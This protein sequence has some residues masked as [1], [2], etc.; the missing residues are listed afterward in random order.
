MI[1]KILA[2]FTRD[3]KVSLKD[4]I[5]LYIII[6]P[7]LFAIV[8]NVFTPGINDST[9][10]LAMLASDDA[11][12]IAYL[13]DFAKVELFS[14]V[15]AIENRIE[16]RDNII[17]IIPEEDSYYLL[18]QGNEP[19]G[20]VE[21]A[22]ALRAFYDYG[23]TVEDSEATIYDF[24]RSTP[25]LKK[26]LVS[27]AIMFISVLGGMLI[28]INIVEEKVDNT[29][30]AIHVTP[31]SRIGYIIGKSAIGVIV[32]II[33]TALMLIFTG[34]TEINYAQVFV[35]LLTSSI[36]SLLVGFIEGLTNDD[37]MNAAGNIKI[38]F[39]P[40][41]GSVAGYE[42]LADK[43]QPFF[44]WIPFYWTYRGN[45]LVLSNSGTW[46][47]ILMYAGFV[48]IISAV[49]FALLAPKIRKGLE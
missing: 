29:I 23:V 28:A 25:P 43:W 10:N 35:L 3:L 39:L 15:K 40:L 27:A 4:F 44:Y 1:K 26:V 42:L 18:L 45:D 38:L 16:K 7:L 32:P 2:I 5:S 19:E 20:I 6:F 37:V 12:Q 30:S 41:L 9:V 49:V 8:I 36:I 46:G 22:K 17:G 47:Q 48:V 34:Y 31:I 21:F 33:G 11:K 24:E 13:Q 14:S